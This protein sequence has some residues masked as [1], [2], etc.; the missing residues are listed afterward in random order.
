MAGPL[1][2]Q[3]CRAES[4]HASV[5]QALELLQAWV[6][7]DRFGAARL[8]AVTRDAMSVPGRPEGPDG[9]VD[10]SAAAVWGA[11]RSAQ[12][13]HPDRFV[14]VDL[15]DEAVSG[16][17][18]ATALAGAEPQYAVRPGGC[19]CRGGEGARRRGHRRAA[20]VPGGHRAGHRRTGTLGALVARHLV[21]EYGVRHLLLL[22]RRGPAAE[23]AAELHAQLTALGAEVTITACDAADR[24]ALSAP[25]PPSHRTPTHRRHPRRSTLDDGILT[26]LTPT[27]RRRHAPQSRRRLEPPRTH[28][29][30][31]TA[32][33]VLF[34]AAGGVLGNPGQVNYAAANA[35]LDALAAQPTAGPAGSVRGLGPVVRRQR[36]DAALDETGCAGCAAPGCWRCPTRTAWRSSTP[37]W[38]RITP[39]PAGPADLAGCGPVP[40]RVRRC[41]WACSAPPAPRRA[42]VAR[43]VRRTA[44]GR[45]GAARPAGGRTAHALV[46]LVAAQAAAVLGHSSS[47]AVSPGRGFL[48]AGFDSLRAVELRTGWPRPPACLPATLA[49]DHPPPRRSP[50]DRRAAGAGGPP[51]PQFSRNSTAWK[52]DCGGSRGRSR[53]RAARRPAARTA[54]TAGRSG[55]RRRGDPT[56]R[57]GDEFDDVTLDEILDIVDSELRK[58]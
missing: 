47:E 31:Q 41:C 21:T 20:A 54:D 39:G 25:S 5:E 17:V 42:P 2:E 6:A 45:S 3:A 28:P 1:R 8:V 16:R 27:T 38:P 44:G 12:A 13:E 10:P 56:G 33:F 46:E 18:L 52:P 29:R 48:E 30:N 24:D 58:S 4:A 50:R 35:Y 23:G 9:A 36:H 51:D 55:V 49:F 22:S 40:R 15:D 11:V 7:D 37:H 26:S 14:L 34:S 43:T 53:P 57:W 19:W 32:L